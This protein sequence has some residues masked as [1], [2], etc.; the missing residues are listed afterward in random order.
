MIKNIFKSK[1]LKIIVS[2]MMLFSTV[3]TV[4]PVTAAE[5][6]TGP[7]TRVK[8]IK[9]PSWWADKIPGVKDWST[10]MCTFNGQW[11]YCLEASKNTP[12]NGSYTASIIRNNPMVKKLLYYGFG[13]P[14]QCIFQDETDETAYLYT[15]V[16]LSIAYSGDMCGA[17]LDALENLGIGLK[18][19]YQYISDLP[20]PTDA[21]FNGEDTG[22]F[23]ADYDSVNKEQK[24]NIITF[25]AGSN[26][27]ANVTLQEGVTLHNITKG[28]SGSGTVTIYGGD[29]I[30][31]TAP[32][33]VTQD[34]TS[35]NIAGNNCMSF[36]PLAI[37]G[38]S[39]TQTHGSFHTD[40][41]IIRYMVNWLDAGALELTKTN[42]NTDLIDGAV[43]NLKST[44]YD[45]YS[46]DITVTGGKLLV[47]YLPVGTYELKEIQAPDG[48]LLNET[49]YTVTVNKDQT[50]TQT[51]VNEEPTGSI[52]LT[53][54]IN[55]DLTDGNTG[56]A[57]L[58]G[59][60]YTLKAKEKITNKAG[61]VTYFEK[62]AV[63]DT[64]TTDE[65]GKLKFDELHVGKYYIE[66]SKANETLVLNPK[67]INVNIDYEGQ[68]VSKILRSASTDNR[69]N[70]QKIKIFKAG[71]KDAESGIIAGLANAEFT[72]KLKSEVDQVGWDQATVY[73][74]ITTDKNGNANTKY[75]PYGTYLVKETATPK[76]YI[77][78]PDFTVEI[79]KDYTEYPDIE[80]IKTVN[81]NNRPYTSQLKIVKKDLDS[82]KTVS[83]NSTTFKVKAREDIVSNGKV[84]Y[85]AGD[86]VK[87]K[88]SGKWYDSFTTNADNTVVSDGSFQ[89]DDSDKGTVMLPLQLDAGKYYIDEIKTPQGY[90]SLENRVEFDIENIRDY[91]KDE[92]G[93]PILEITVSNDK[94]VGEFEIF[95]DISYGVLIPEPRSTV[96][97]NGTDLVERN[98]LS[99][100][101]F[102]LTAKEAV[103]DPADGEIIY[104]KGATVGEY[105]LSSDGYLMVSNLPMGTGSAEYQLQEIETL[106]GLVLDTNKYD[107]VFTQ[108][109]LTKKVYTVQKNITN[110][111]TVVELSKKTVTGEEELSGAEMSVTDSSG[112]VIA[113]W[114][115]GE[116]PYI[117]QG[118]KVN[119]TYTLRENLAPLGYVKATDIEF[120][121]EN[122]GEIQKI[123]MTDKI[124]TVNKTD[125]QGQGLKGATLQVVSEKTKNIV[126]QWTADESGSHKVSG[127]TAGETYIL[128][129]IKVPEG[130]TRALDIK[131]TVED[132]N[133]NQTVTM[134][135]KKVIISKKDLGGNELSGAYMQILD[136][137]GNVV[138]E[139]ISDGDAYETSNLSVG[140]TYTLK[141]DLAPL[142]YAV[143][144]SIEFTVEDN[145]KDQTVTMTDTAVEVNKT[146]ENG[147]QL[148]GATLQIVS[149][150]TKNIVDQWISGRHIFDIDEEIKTEL[151]NGETVSDMYIDM[152]DDSTVQYSIK[153][154][155][156]SNDYTL[157]TVKAGE[158]NYYIIDINGD[159]TRHLVRNLIQNQDYTLVE[160]SAPDGYATASPQNFTVKDKNITLTMTDEDTKV[161]ISKQ[162]ITTQKEL[163]GATLQVADKD[164]NI[165]DEWV[166]GKEPHMIRNLT[167]NETY[168]LT[169]TIAPVNYQVAQSINF[170]VK[171]T[172]EVQQVIMYD[173]LMPVKKV[174]TGDSSQ[175]VSLYCALSGMSIIG[176]SF[177]KF[178]KRKN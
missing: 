133:K 132:D 81:I 53:K 13:G 55:S 86:T 31:L 33:T 105:N 169:E 119:N 96:Y 5:S 57:Y 52:D 147:K 142:G 145:G 94:P 65:Q 99:K 28:T 146:D 30:Y 153:P 175:M 39:G 54:E 162:D 67:D 114:I 104:A 126:D 24:T 42:T 87:Q 111:P 64:Q 166:S 82:G 141:E 130:Y 123:K 158:A 118:L 102:R 168:T 2:V 43:F 160:V 18:S 4:T 78:A 69:V 11:S 51:V 167:A 139:W 97:E 1:I 155:K 156:E 112:N 29:Q 50:T 61:T 136:K 38:G 85:H 71:E 74:V 124:L 151:L 23:T 3:F 109:D 56:D 163:E 143:S 44:S 41:G 172:G 128:Q 122:T 75:L 32:M 107:I 159:E 161:E 140:E 25:N 90:L 95:K 149:Q 113:E 116:N 89:T 62:D 137:D 72:F 103:I 76:D 129:E 19:V 148:K 79:T 20:E 37:G 14:A 46:E 93:D 80:Q 131:F 157:M 101:K 6:Y 47:E 36:V 106:D 144:N 174:K 59:N 58:Q 91:D 83:L 77:T 45:G 134:T 68:T 63:V 16:L 170:T 12:A 152:N 48:Y 34:Y 84:I 22:Y 173:E 8:E 120:T 171:D 73:D 92:D 165:I 98:D 21:N 110:Y 121:V 15:H 70:M 10:W 108:E 49:V 115:S 154:N 27:T 40:P 17:D 7:F 100:I 176:I 88:I 9:Y 177:I 66:E 117:I 26:A 60:E 127:L 35:D 150:K 135:D 138:E 178:R 164:G 125:A